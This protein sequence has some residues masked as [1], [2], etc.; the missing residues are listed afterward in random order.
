MKINRRVMENKKWA[1]PYYEYLLK[2]NSNIHWRIDFD[3]PVFKGEEYSSY[4]QAKNYE[5]LN[6]NE[7]KL[8]QIR[9]VL[10]KIEEKNDAENE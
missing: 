3:N 7:K 8:R 1:I 6:V 5:K 9:L 2:E 4:L 10:K